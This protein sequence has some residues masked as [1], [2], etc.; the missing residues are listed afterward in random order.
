MVV[1]VHRFAEQLGQR[2]TSHPLVGAER[3]RRV[4]LGAVGHLELADQGGFGV[5]PPPIG[6]IDAE[7]GEHELTG[8]VGRPRRCRHAIGRHPDQLGRRLEAE[9]DAGES[10]PPATA[11]PIGGSVDC[12]CW[13]R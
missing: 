3:D 7:S 11:A 2:L 5:G 8:G 9:V 10:R 1:G 12:R 4:E 13:S 6:R